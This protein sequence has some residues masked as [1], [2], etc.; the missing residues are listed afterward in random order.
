M[1]DLRRA[2]ETEA[3]LALN[4]SPIS[5]IAI[6]AVEQDPLLAPNVARA[7]KH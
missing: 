1:I 2:A 6:V 4:L 3:T 5:A 7:R